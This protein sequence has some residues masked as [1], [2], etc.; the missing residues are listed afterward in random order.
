[1][2][3]HPLITGSPLSWDLTVL[4]TGGGWTRAMKLTETTVRH[5]RVSACRRVPWTLGAHEPRDPDKVQDTHLTRDEPK[6]WL[7]ICCLRVLTSQLI[8]RWPLRLNLSD[9]CVQTEQKE[10]NQSSDLR[11]MGWHHTAWDEFE[12]SRLK[13]TTC[14]FPLAWSYQTAEASKHQS[15]A[16]ISVSLKSCRR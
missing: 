1:M 3:A 10:V 4:T 6:P 16:V 15:R 7:L 13:G 8:S 9:L 5:G 11:E 2:V 14:G 12:D